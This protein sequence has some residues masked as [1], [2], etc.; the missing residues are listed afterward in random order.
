MVADDLG[1]PGNIRR[2]LEEEIRWAEENKA[3][4]IFIHMDQKRQNLK[5][6]QRK[7]HRT[8]V[9]VR[10]RLRGTGKKDKKQ[11]KNNKAN[12]GNG[13]PQ[14]VE[15]G[16]GVDRH[17][18]L[19]KSKYPE[20]ILEILKE[21]DI[22]IIL[23][24]PEEDCE[25]E[26]KMINGRDLNMISYLRKL[27]QEEP[28][29]IYKRIGKRMNE[30]EKELTKKIINEP[31][32]EKKRNIYYEYLNSGSE[33]QRA[34][35]M[36][37]IR[38]KKVDMKIPNL[39]TGIEGDEPD[40]NAATGNT[41][42]YRGTASVADTAE[43][44]RWRD[45]LQLINGKLNN[46]NR[47]LRRSYAC[48]RQLATGLTGPAQKAWTYLSEKD[49]PRT[50][51]KSRNEESR[52]H[53]E[54]TEMKSSRSNSTR[55][56]DTRTSIQTSNAMGNE[57]MTYVT[58]QLQSQGPERVYANH[59]RKRE[60]NNT[61]KINFEGKGGGRMNGSGIFKGG[62]EGRVTYYN[63]GKTGHMAKE[64]RGKKFGHTS[65][66]CPN[67]KAEEHEKNL[68]CHKCEGNG[69]MAKRHDD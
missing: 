8:L 12:N 65:A 4:G 36:R 1:N 23:E 24:T 53:Q 51:E 16:G 27:L 14:H 15:C 61:Y 19:R 66:N 6:I 47:T 46:S 9:R 44:N 43:G 52:A 69:H 68:R 7:K 22:P 54:W 40:N 18:G 34:V 20:I 11:W 67:K 26:I 38:E 41:V 64:C 33:E 30:E 45:G 60:I 42:N 32:D 37:Q 49:Q 17:E 50:L 63:C 56:Q 55:Q 62:F 2:D 28:E 21:T 10:T 59:E 57:V 29:K 48:I 3:E 31:N 35:A 13:I 5:N 25:N 58:S 39:P